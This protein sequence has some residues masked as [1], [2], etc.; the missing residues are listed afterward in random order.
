MKR[1]LKNG[2]VMLAADE[3]FNRFDVEAWII[4]Q[5]GNPAHITQGVTTFKQRQ[6]RIRDEIFRLDLASSPATKKTKQTWAQVYERFYGERLAKPVTT[7]QRKGKQ[8]VLP[9]E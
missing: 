2:H 8:H 9:T 6:L 4:G 7:E 5:L 1:V 3:H